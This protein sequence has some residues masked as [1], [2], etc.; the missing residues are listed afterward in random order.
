MLL[1]ILEM[2]LLPSV[3][4]LILILIGL[5]L[6]NPVRGFK[7]SKGLK[8][9]KDKIGWFLLFLGITFYY[10]FSI[11]PI[12]DLILLPLERQ[13][14]PI[15]EDELAKADKIVLLLGGRETNVLR[16]SEIL[17]LYFLKQGNV[18][19]IISGRDPIDDEKKEAEEV[20]RYL[21]E[22]GILSENIILENKSRNTFES[23]KNIKK[24]VDKEPFFLVTSA[25]HL[26]RA[27]ETFKQRGISPIPAPADFRIK[28]TD[29][30]FDFFPCPKNLRNSNLGLREYFAILYYRLILF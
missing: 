30:V 4:L 7:T 17:R 25:Y 15:L 9:K 18:Q 6:V 20:K 22:R 13:E 24:L 26:P 1:K 21:T 3:F 28:G 16:A 2:F 29:D 10:L 23:A 11:T 19:I 12:A 5:I 8:K 27:I 14:Q